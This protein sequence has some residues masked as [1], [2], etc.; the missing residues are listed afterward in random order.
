[1]HK[2][3]SSRPANLRLTIAMDN[4]MSDRVA[5]MPDDIGT[6]QCRRGANASQGKKGVRKL[7]HHDCYNNKSETLD[8]G[9]R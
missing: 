8:D 7:E 2:P 9:R 3:F 5:L 6:A 1:M 4:F